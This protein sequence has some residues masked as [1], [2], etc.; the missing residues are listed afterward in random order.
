M[1][2]LSATQPPTPVFDSSKD[3]GTWR[4]RIQEIV[5]YKYLLQ[6]LVIRDLKTRYKNSILGILWSLLNPLGMMLVFTIVFTVLSQNNTQRQFPVFVL[7]GLMPWNFFAGAINQGAVSIL[8]NSSL[9]KKVY[10]PRELLPISS[11]LSNLVNFGVTFLVLVVFLYAFGLKLTLNAFWVVP[12][13]IIQMVF[14]LGLVFLLSAAAVFYRDVLMIL[15]V[16]MLGWFFLTPIFY[17]LEMFGPSATLLSITFV[18]A[19]V[20][21]WVNPMAS[22]IDGYRTVLW[23]TQGS[24]GPVSMNIVF[25]LRTF[26]TSFITLIIGYAA[27]TRTEHLFGEKL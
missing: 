10:F 17:P 13:L 14:T 23:G 11:L 6:N 5:Q 24:A 21:R 12:I 16:L 26:A 22:I 20:M 9:V 7:V 3:Q 18:P 4:Q 27:F 19:Q 8:G 1:S 2:E 15:E 25:L